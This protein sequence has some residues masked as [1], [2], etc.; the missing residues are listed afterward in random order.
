[1]GGPLDGVLVC[2]LTRVLS[3]PYC[4]Q[5]LADLGAQ[6]IKVERPGTGDDTRAWG[7]PFVG[8]TAAYFMS[9]NR[10]KQ[11]IAVDLKH[12]DGLAAVRRLAL[13]ADVLV[14]N[15]RPG[16][17]DELGLGYAALS[18]EN[19]GLIYA[20]ISGFGQTGPYRERAG[21]DAIAQGMGGMMAIT[22][23]PDGAPVR[24]GVAIA[25]IGAGMF[26]AF[27]IASALVE[28]A[29]SGRGQQVDC[30][31][32]DAQVAWMTYAAANFFATG[33]TPRRYGSAHPSIVPYQAVAVGDG[34]IMLAVGNDA[35]WRRFCAAI[36]EP[37]LAANVAYATNPDRVAHR[38]ELL[39]HLD[40]RLR[41]RGMAQWLE[42]FERAG[43]PAG[44][45]YTMPQVVADP[46]VQAR[47][48]VV[49]LPHP[50]AGQ[51]RVTGNPVKLSR[52]PGAVRSAPPLLG[53]H[54]DEVLTFLGYGRE[55]VARL[56]AAGAVQ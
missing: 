41:Q 46:Q 33:E 8:G 35:I 42:A 20:S 37:E 56:R 36:G 31:L 50:E 47:E 25:D 5:M 54:T 7:P 43:V 16:T 13:R 21:Y 11:S 34:F 38:E 22:G 49:A 4:T 55:E 44:P 24:A 10:N 1:M 26:A 32:V 15:F 9:A 2:D 23:E 29:R 40:R 52:T 53:Q 17:A 14:E 19:P 6:V 28:R 3:G 45:I 12:P 27:G 48:M 18:A 51:V 39:A 30:A